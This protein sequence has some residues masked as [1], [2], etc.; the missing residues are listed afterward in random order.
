MH[1]IIICMHY[2]L[3][4]KSD[5]FMKGLRSLVSAES[6]LQQPM[7]QMRNAC[8]QRV[9]SG[10]PARA[11]FWRFRLPGLLRYYTMSAADC[12]NTAW[13]CQLPQTIDWFTG[14]GVQR[15]A[16]I[17]IFKLAG[18]AAKCLCFS[19][20]KKNFHG[21]SNFSRGSYFD[22]FNGK[23]KILKITRLCAKLLFS[24]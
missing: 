22:I 7:Q 5:H 21:G 2:S 1:I 14:S 13:R 4:A 9:L 12:R 20:W 19:D 24:I 3:L 23:F 15:S 16:W 8:Q 11:L 17:W 6:V 18:V 10:H